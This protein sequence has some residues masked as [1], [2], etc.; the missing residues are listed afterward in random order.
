MIGI[1]DERW[2][3]V[4]CAYIVPAPGQAPQAAELVTHCRSLIA[5]YKVPKDF[6]LVP[7]LP[8]TGSGKVMKH[9]LR[10]A[11]RAAVR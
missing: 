4:G 5:H 7:E 2:G 6:R 8:R 3:E 9:V 11:A 10:D 1:P